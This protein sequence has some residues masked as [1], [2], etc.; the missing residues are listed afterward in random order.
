MEFEVL[1]K[2]LS[3]VIKRISYKVRRRSANCSPE[4]LYQEAL[5]RLWSEF[6]A[7]RLADKTDS[8]ILQ[9]CYFHLKNYIRKYALAINLVSLNNLENQDGQEIN[10]DQVLHLDHSLPLREKLHCSM[11]IDQINNNGLLPRE[12][13]VFRLLLEG[14]TIREIGLSLGISHVMVIKI[15]KS[16]LKK[17]LEHMDKI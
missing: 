12:K 10:L 4:D 5:L 7:G 17:C 3:P 11:L 13:E 9:G 15:K 1:L 8:Y 16:M 6:Q 2:R 14:R